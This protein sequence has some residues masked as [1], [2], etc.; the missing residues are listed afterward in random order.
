MN[1]S[2]ENATASTCSTPSADNPAPLYR[3]RGIW[4]RLRLPLTIVAMLILPFIAW[5]FALA[6]WLRWSFPIGVLVTLLGVALRV[7]AAGWLH[8]HQGVGDERAV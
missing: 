2:P 3:Q 5:K 7:W 1:Q 8:K 4:A 6:S